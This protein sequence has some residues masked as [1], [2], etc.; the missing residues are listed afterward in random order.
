MWMRVVSLWA[1]GA[2]GLIW[3]QTDRGTI[4]GSVTDPSGA[5]IVGAKVTA[6]NTATRASTETITTSTGKYTVPLLR[7]G[8]YEVTVEQTGFKKYIQT[9]VIVEVGQTVRVDA[10]MQL[11]EA[12]QTVE[13]T[14]GAVQVQTE[15]SDRGT[16]V[17]GRE[18]LD[19]P[20]V[21]QGEQRNPAFFINLS[22]GVTSRG[23]STPTASGS[24]RLLNTTVNGSPSASTEFHFDGLQIGNAG[25]LSGEFRN[26]PFPQDA[27]A[28]FKIVT[29]S[30]P[31]EYGRSGLGVVTFTT[32]SGTNQFHGSVYEYLRNE[33][34]DARGFFAPRTPLNKQ[35][36]FGATAGG[37]IRKDK[38]F[39]FGWYQG[40]RLRK[41]ASNSLDTVPTEAMRNGNLSNILGAQFTTDA[42]GRPVYAGQIYDPATTRTV[43]AGAV[44]PVSGLTN[45]SGST[46]ILRD[47]FG[48]SPVTG[49]PIPGQANIIPSNR[50]DPVAKAMYAQFPNPT[51]P[52]QAFGYQNNW[53]SQ[54]KNQATINEW[55]AKIDHSLSSRNKVMGEFVWLRNHAPTG[56]KWPGAI[57]E[58]ATNDNGQYITRFSH[59]LVLRPNLVNHWIIGYN[60]WR[61]D[62][63]PEGGL[64][65]PQKLGYKGVPQTG[66]G[67]TFPQLIIGGLGNVYARGNQ[68]YSATN[69]YMIDEGLTW[70]KGKHSFKMGFSYIKFQENGASLGGQS[71]KLNFAAGYTALPLTS[72]FYTDSCSPGGKCTGVG[73]ASFLL[74]GVGSATASLYGAVAADRAGQYAGYF[75]DDFKATSRLTFNIG[76]RYDLMLPTVN[77]HNQKSW[78]DPSVVNP[79][80]GIKGAMVFATDSRRAPVNAFT[81]AFGPRFGFAYALNDKTVLRGGYGI[82]YAAAGFTRTSGTSFLQG[83]NANY[84][85]PSHTV[86]GYAGLEP[87]FSLNDGWPSSRHAPPPF[88]SPSYG[89]GTGPL[90]AFGDGRIPDIQNWHLSLQRELPGKMLI[91]VGYVGTKGTHL[92][93]RL[94]PTTAVNTKY[95][96]LGD[97]LFKIISDPSVQALPVVQSMPVDPATGNHTPFSGF[98][99]L[100][101]GNALLAQA[102]RPFPQYGKD[103]PNNGLAQMRDWGET[104]GLST[105]HALQVQARKQFSNG[106]AFLTSY[107]WSKTLSDAESLFNE[108]SGFTQDFYNKRAEKSLSLLDFPQNL[109]LSY[110]YELPFGP[111]RKFVNKGGAPGKILGG[112]MFAGL[113]QYT[114][115][116]PQTINSANSLDPYFGANSFQTRPNVV[117]GVPR[118]SQAYLDGTWDPNAPGAAGSVFNINAW[119]NPQVT[120]RYSL[121]NAPRT[122]GDIRRFPYYNEDF[123]IIKRTQITERVKV[124]FRADFLNI[125]NRTVFGFDQGGDQYGNTIQGTVLDWGSGSFGHVTSQGNFPREIQFGLKINY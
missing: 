94:L 83:Y 35:N 52:G 92:P 64:D 23:T 82:L 95:L 123:S 110:Q 32:R 29:V 57:S 109:T 28:E 15:T 68:G 58:G 73:A 34:L 106:L 72:P 20:I 117:P 103:T 36:E 120:N 49:L 53:L 116:A 80:I 77:A 42:L 12:T 9:G 105:Y 14:A 48:F 13:V 107:T 102:L 6:T 50:I 55:G 37:P 19:L 69:N 76:L 38:T 113:H 61:T 18:V 1:F 17:T 104:S 91:D 7:P 90:A 56:S 78:M 85:E 124:E 11:G 8:T 84:D 10:P 60:R 62:Y 93:S 63:F 5:V 25:Q 16:V 70:I 108:F 74:G 27:V 65:W 51:L 100:W 59:D 24:G 114:S 75:Q 89:L 111:G 125:F 54:F 44:D 33:K 96:S 30:P 99:N 98:E 97:A 121:G 4:T 43:A 22:P 3:A 2:A 119:V 87:A 88:I 79:D 67:S 31:A 112:W 118:R 81:K 86:S 45:N 122:N 41:E 40:F 47:G 115:G 21:G 66:A 39:F 26:L 101:K 46:A 71:S